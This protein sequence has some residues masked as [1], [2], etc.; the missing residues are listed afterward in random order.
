MPRCLRNP[1]RP[2]A[3]CSSCQGD[4]NAVARKGVLRDQSRNIGRELAPLLN[5]WI[6]PQRVTGAP[7][8]DM[9]EQPALS[10]LQR[11]LQRPTPR[12]R[13]RQPSVLQLDPTR[14]ARR[15][16]QTI[17]AGAQP[18]PTITPRNTNTT[19]R[20]RHPRRTAR[21]RESLLDPQR[22]ACIPLRNRTPVDHDTIS[23]RNEA[24]HTLRPHNPPRYAQP[25][26][27]RSPTR[28]RHPPRTTPHR[29]GQVE[30]RPRHPAARSRYQTGA[31]GRCAAPNRGPPKPPSV[32]STAKPPSRP[33]P[34]RGGLASYAARPWQ[35]EPAARPQQRRAQRPASD[36]A[37]TGTNTTP[38]STTTAQS[39]VAIRSRRDP[40]A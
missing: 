3:S 20:P 13:R 21:D 40:M 35:A 33:A 1:L 39:R 4:R 28:P 34:A 37:E 2:S 30:R 22:P 16:E 6:D 12:I 38:T 10:Q 19:G 18:T 25:L 26:E 7:I 31:H 24:R 29:Q 9:K 32:P 14:N 11:R 5:Q 27:T 23:A 15:T 36:P 17:R 8:T